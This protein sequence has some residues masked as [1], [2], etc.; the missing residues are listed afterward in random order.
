MP[1]KKTKST[2]AKAKRPSKAKAKPTKASPRATRRGAGGGPGSGLPAAPLTRLSLAETKRHVK[3]IIG[4]Q[5]GENPNTITDGS[6]VLGRPN[7]LL[8]HLIPALNRH[9]F[10][11]PLNGIVGF[12]DDATVVDLAEQ[13]KITRDPQL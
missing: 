5:S 1:T 4:G 11:A 13:I 6:Q 10:P 3:E 9:F 7:I 2:K 8:T 12:P